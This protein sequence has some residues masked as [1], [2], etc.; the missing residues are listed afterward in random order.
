MPEFV[1]PL[2][3][4]LCHASQDKPSVRELR[5]RLAAE[6]WIDPWLDEEK[7]SLGQH[8][9]TVIEEALDSSDLVIIFLSKNSVQKEGFVQR[10]LN[11]AWELSLEKPRNVIFL[12]PF[13]LDDCEVPR[14]LRSRQWGDYFGEKKEATYQNLLESLKQRKE[15]KLRL[16]GDWVRNETQV[17]SPA[18]KYVEQP[19]EIQS[20]EKTFTR[21]GHPI[22]KFGVIE[23]VKVPMGKFL[24]GSIDDKRASNNEKPQHAVDIPYDYY[25][26]RFPMMNEQYATYAHA[27][28]IKHPVSGWERE[29]DHPVVNVSW[30]DAVQY[31]RWLNDLQKNELLS[32]WVFRLPTEAEWEKA[33]R[34]RNS[35]VYPWGDS[36]D[37]NKCNTYEGAIG[38]TSP[39]GRYSPQGDSPYGC[40]DLS[41]NVWEWTHSLLKVYPYNIRDGRE[42]EGS[43]NHV[44]RGGC[45]Y[46][47]SDYARCASRGDPLFGYLDDLIGFRVV[48]APPIP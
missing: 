41:G 13:R 29:R 28:R 39:V 48:V 34:G 42:V 43:G 7:L 17:I 10:E 33:A 37:K 27:K 2:H 44:L 47:K 6:N 23:F 5:K 21:S 14:H 45:F 36:F 9:T 26:A 4:F 35:L 3:V 38:N 16:E 15:Q 25:L 32:N 20:Q 12:I 30:D 31:C 19:I 22:Y 46:D 8:W 18:S 40:S 11:Y 1:R 24:M